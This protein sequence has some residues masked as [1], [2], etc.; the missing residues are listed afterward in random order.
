MCGEADLHGEVSQSEKENQKRRFLCTY[1][2]VWGSK[3]RRLENNSNLCVM[4]VGWYC[5]TKKGLI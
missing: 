5:T 2:C 1:K 3:K 4:C